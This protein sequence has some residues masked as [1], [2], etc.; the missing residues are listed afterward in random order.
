MTIKIKKFILIGILSAGIGT[1]YVFDY[2]SNQSRQ[3]ASEA[4][5]Q[6]LANSD[7]YDLSQ[8]TGSTFQKAFKYQTLKNALIVKDHNFSSI[9][10]GLF[11][12]QDEDQKTVTMCD[13]YPT[14][15]YIFSADGVAVSG[16]QPTMILRIPCQVSFDKRHTSVVTIPFKEIFAGKAGTFN[17]PIASLDNQEEGR[18]YIYN[19][20]NEWPQDWVWTGLKLYDKKGESLSINGYEIISVLGEPPYIHEEVITE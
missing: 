13:K 7:L 6:A 1:I 2:F 11:L 18:L 14:L 8:S 20:L 4:D 16:K 12:V 15:D 19:D 3:M 5:A 9:Q 10:V 17:L